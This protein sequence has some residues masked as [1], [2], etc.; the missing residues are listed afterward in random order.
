MTELSSLVEIVARLRSEGGCPWDRAQTLKSMRP[1]LLEEVYE[2]LEALD[3]EDP[4]LLKKELGDLLFQIIFLAQTAE[5]AG[6]FSFTDVVAGINAKMIHRHPHV[7]DP[8]YTTSG[9]E[10][11]IEAWEAR[12]A[13][14]RQNH[15][16]SLDG[17][18]RQLP[19]LLRAHRISEKASRVGFDWEDREGVLAKLDEELQELG[20]A[21][22]ANDEQKINEEFGDVL[23]TLVNLGRRLPSTAEDALR[24]ATDRF[25]ERFRALEESLQ[26]DGLSFH[27]ADMRTLEDRWR[28]VKR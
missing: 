2:V 28:A 9:G 24:T 13:E 7:F 4:A 3:R 12:K 19:A 11:E 26:S 6:D 14:E 27:T 20:E 10:G 17:V 25:S 8:T 22:E 23:F 16:S 18:P 5:E 21:L 15:G 1:Y